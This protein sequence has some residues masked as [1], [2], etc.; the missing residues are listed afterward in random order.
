M[1]CLYFF[2]DFFVM[3][4]KIYEID[5]PTDIKSDETNKYFAT[6]PYPYMNGKI[7]R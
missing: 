7:K 1:S 5:A 2:F 4:A 3:I 6:F